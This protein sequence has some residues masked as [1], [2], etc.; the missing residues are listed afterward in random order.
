MTDYLKY[1]PENL[2]NLKPY[3]PGKTT[4]EIMRTYGLD[5]V[6]KL[7]S[8]ENPLGPSP[9]VKQAV[10]NFIQAAARYPE[11][12]A[13]RLKQAL[14]SAADVSPEQIILGAG[15]SEILEMLAR[16]FLR[17][18]DNLI[19]SEHGFVLYKILAT[20]IGAD[21]NII[22]DKNY[23]QDP[24]A[25]LAAIDVHTRMI[26]LAN[27]NNPTGTW[28]TKQVLFDFIRQVPSDVIVVIDEAY[29]EYMLDEA[30]CSSV[31][32]IKECN[33]LVVVRTFS[34]VYGLAGMRFGYSISSLQVA[35]LL[36]RLRKAF[37]VSSVTLVA[38]LAA[39]E[40]HAYTQKVVAENMRGC[41][42]LVSCFK[43]LGLPMLAQSGNFITI[44]VGE[45]A[46]DIAAALLKQGVIVRPLAPYN[47]PH[48]LRISIGTREE[49]DFL[50]QNLPACLQNP[51]I[52]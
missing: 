43:E 22:T 18:G 33:N 47:M 9:K 21:N 6:V 29:A 23:Q 3:Q 13:P 31:E 12:C 40:D 24:Q 37:N 46:T 25:M 32:L 15:S 51:D 5:S 27:P 8:N 38:A 4:D 2:T 41:E 50:I 48:H 28:L 1:I 17:P 10:C 14:A 19:S 11:D 44:E 35:D 39:F 34:K 36:G 30:Y 42:Q 20:A 52:P 7:A 16:L 26:M 45:Q 49:N